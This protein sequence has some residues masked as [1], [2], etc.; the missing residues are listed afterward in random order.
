MPTTTIPL[1][2]QQTRR[3]FGIDVSTTKD[4]YFAA[5]L[6]I[7]TVNQ[8]EGSASYYLQKRPGI[9][10]DGNL[11]SGAGTA[12]FKSPSTGYTLFAFGGG[13]STIIVAGVYT[14]GTITG[15][16][17]SIIETIINGVT[18]YL[19]SS[20][21]GT[22]WYLVSTAGSQTAYTADGNNSTTITDIKISGVNNT[23]G[24]YPGQLL[25]AAT[26]IV[27]GSRIVS[28]DAAAFT[29]VLDTATT[30]GAFNDLAIT[31]T[32]IAKIQS[33][34]FPSMVGSFAEMDGYVFA[35]NS[36]G[37]IFNSDINTVTT[38]QASSKIVAN[39]KTDTAVTL[40]RHKNHIVCFGE[41][42][43]E[44][45]INFGNA[46]GSILA[47]RKELFTN[48]GMFSTAATKKFTQIFDHVFWIGNDLCLYTFQE[49]SPV[50]LNKEG[51]TL[52]TISAAPERISSFTIGADIIVHINSS[53]SARDKWYSVINNEFFDPV[54]GVAGMIW[55]QNLPAETT[56][57]A[58]GVSS[59]VTDGNVYALRSNVYQDDGSAFTMTI[60]TQP[61][62]LNNGKGFT[63]NRV[64]LL[65]D[66]QSSGA[67]ALETSSDDYAS[68]VTRGSF[69]LTRDNKEI[70]R[71]GYHR[72]SCAFRIT[73]SG[74]QAWRGQA[75]VVDWEPCSA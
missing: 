61:Y 11:G 33:A 72:S 9:N 12:I 25:T 66:K 5:A 56:T 1:I 47:A 28:V 67:S 14:A 34:N 18:H 36:K 54:M 57:V 43:T 40:L 7:K 29:A 26:N 3:G 22:G 53:T 45:F 63:V 37:E 21:D 2:G 27:A 69:D 59:S 42:S 75:I 17:H 44:F 50:N 64:R 13:N 58:S 73:D 38:W 52:G 74:N 71:C 49:L 10:D 8:A 35:V 31:K 68:W 6:A 15:L 20:S 30:G 19:F 16:C 55:S 62:S 70:H 60:Q 48:I 23:A 39:L 24:L 46:F 51:M 4:Q 65:A 32:P 41:S